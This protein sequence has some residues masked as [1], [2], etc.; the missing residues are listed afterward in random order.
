MWGEGAAHL[1]ER[2]GQKGPLPKIYF[3]Y[4]TMMKLGVVVPQRYSHA[5]YIMA[6]I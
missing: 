4:P 3:S 1:C 6:N 5:N 2:R